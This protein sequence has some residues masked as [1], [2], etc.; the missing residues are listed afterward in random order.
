MTIQTIFCL[1]HLSL[2]VNHIVDYIS[3]NVRYV[4]SRVIRIYSGLVSVEILCTSKIVYLL[5]IFMVLAPN[6]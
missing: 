1:D 4:C 5:L 6:Y 3:L 2:A